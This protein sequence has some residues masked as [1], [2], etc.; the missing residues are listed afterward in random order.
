MA[1]ERALA[2]RREAALAQMAAL[3]ETFTAVLGVAPLN[4]NDPTRHRD[5]A[6]AV[7]EVFE[8]VAAFIEDVAHKVLPAEA[9]L[10][11][12][13]APPA[14]ALA[15]ILINRRK[16]EVMKQIDALNDPDDLRFLIAAELE[17]K[18]RPDVLAAL[19]GR[20]D[21]YAAPETPETP[22]QDEMPGPETPAAPENPQ[23]GDS[24]A[25]KHGETGETAQEPGEDGFDAALPDPEGV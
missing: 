19:Q 10:A 14:P 15:D 9:Y 22:A 24:D 2:I 13:N 25:I 8:I 4:L 12:D 23:V 21:A 7:T 1:S 11:A 16:A 17:G 5:P 20:L 3:A 18:A 6:V